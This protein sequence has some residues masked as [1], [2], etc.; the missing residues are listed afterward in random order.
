[1]EVL[2]LNH[3]SLRLFQ[4]KLSNV[5]LFSPQLNRTQSGHREYSGL[6]LVSAQQQ[7]DRD[8]EMGGKQST[9]TRFF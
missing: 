7:N 6:F 5:F 4:V 3:N 2:F 8:E 1:M 9:I